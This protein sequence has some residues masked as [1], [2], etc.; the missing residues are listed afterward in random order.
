MYDSAPLSFVVFFVLLGVAY[1]AIR[2]VYPTKKATR[3]DASPRY[4]LVKAALEDKIIHWVTDKP[5]ELYVHLDDKFSADGLEITRDKGGFWVNVEDKHFKFGLDSVCNRVFE[6]VWD[7]DEL[8]ARTQNGALESK[9]DPICTLLRML[10]VHP[11]L[12]TQVDGESSYRVLRTVFDDYAFYFWHSSLNPHYTHGASARLSGEAAELA[13]SL[14]AKHT[15][16]K[17]S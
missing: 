16:R 10:H 11:E 14:F 17:K 3:V 7:A 9:K 13:A 1:W 8:L 15:K 5:P 4:P 2:V 12:I 6:K